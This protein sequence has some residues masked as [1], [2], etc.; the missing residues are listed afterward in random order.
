MFKAA[1]VTASSRV[2]SCMA[3]DDKRAF[4]EIMPGLIGERVRLL[5]SHPESLA[6]RVVLDVTRCGVIGQPLAYT[7]HVYSSRIRKFRR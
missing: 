6:G 7:P 4:H 5:F 3:P 2:Q 1:S